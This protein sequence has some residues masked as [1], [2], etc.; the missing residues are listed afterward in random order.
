[1]CWSSLS[2]LGLNIHVY[3][4]VI[5]VSS[6]EDDP[7]AVFENLVKHR[8]LP[9]LFQNATYDSAN[10]FRQYVLLHNNHL[11]EE[12]LERYV[13]RAFHATLFTRVRGVASVATREWQLTLVCM[14][15]PTSSVSQRV[16]CVQSIEANLP[17]NQL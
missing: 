5:V 8:N 14:R 9:V 7:L 6:N 10:M 15:V 1:M 16:D 12:V 3:A 13:E 2:F 11:G 4:G 17:G